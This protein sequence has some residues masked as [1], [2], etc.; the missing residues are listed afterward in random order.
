MEEEIQSLEQSHRFCGFYLL[1][2][3]AEKMTA[4]CVRGGG[5]VISLDDLSDEKEF[6]WAIGLYRALL[7]AAEQYIGCSPG[8]KSGVCAVMCRRCREE[9][10]EHL[11]PIC[12]GEKNCTRF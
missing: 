10:A 8:E 11:E 9:N 4:V 12:T 6:E 1:R 7:D 2:K 3:V 5:P